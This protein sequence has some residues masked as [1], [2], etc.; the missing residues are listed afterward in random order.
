MKLKIALFFI[1]LTF[2]WLDAE[3]VIAAYDFEIPGDIPEI[4]YGEPSISD[5]SIGTGNTLRLRGKVLQEQIRI[6]VEISSD[7]VLISYEVLSKNLTDSDYSFSFSMDTTQ[8]RVIYMHGGNDSFLIYI[9]FER[10]GELIPYADEVKYEVKHFVDLI[11]DRWRVYVNGIL[12]YNGRFYADSIYSIRFT[13]GPRLGT[14]R[15]SDLD[16]QLYL[17]NLEVVELTRPLKGWVYKTGRFIYSKNED[18]WFYLY[19]KD[20]LYFYKRDFWLRP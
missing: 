11:K 17:D 8:V 14:V 5:F 1:L 4:K 15:T 10:Q 16:V 2:N 12:I 13:V 18:S 3:N 9:P 7:L 19:N 20:N 6:P